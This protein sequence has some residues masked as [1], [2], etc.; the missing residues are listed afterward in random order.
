MSE[1]FVD[2]LQNYQ[3]SNKGRLRKKTSNGY[4]YIKGSVKD[5]GYRYI[6]LRKNN[7]RYNYY[8]HHLVAEHFIGKRPN[9]KVIDHIDRNKLNNKVTNLR[10]TSVSNNNKNR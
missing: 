2:C 1:Y 10:Y 8:Y 5:N 4:K 6:Q 9:N 7:K 3:I